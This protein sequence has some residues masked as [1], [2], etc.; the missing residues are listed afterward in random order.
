M[1]SFLLSIQC[2][3]PNAVKTVKE[4]FQWPKQ[5]HTSDTVSEMSSNVPNAVE[6]LIKTF[7]KNIKKSSMYHKSANIAY[8]NS[9]KMM[10][11]LISWFVWWDQKYVNIVNLMFL[12]KCSIIIWKYVNQGLKYVIFAKTPSR[13]R[14]MNSIKE[15]VEERWVRKKKKKAEET[16]DGINL[17]SKTVCLSLKDSL[18]KI[19]KL[20]EGLQKKGKSQELQK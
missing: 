13:I 8:L 7:W 12:P 5:A 1:H 6:C 17:N 4:I 20:R 16:R 2:N 3:K 18:T 10:L 14:I 15:F 9:R 11:H 19:N